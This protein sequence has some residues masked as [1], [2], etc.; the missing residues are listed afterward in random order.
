MLIAAPTM[1]GEFVSSSVSHPSTTFSPMFP[2][3]FRNI[4][5]PRQRTLPRRRSETWKMAASAARGG[6]RG[7]T[8]VER[9]GAEALGPRRER[10][11][12]AGP[13]QPVDVDADRRIRAQP[14]QL[15][16]QQRVLALLHERR[17]EP[18]RATDRDVPLGGELRNPLEL[19]VA[20]E[21]GCR[22]LR[23]PA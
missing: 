15:A 14:G 1:N 11:A 18:E 6:E 2:M 20:R 5:A 3:E 10:G 17:R 8:L 21:D 16:K 9:R 23:A 13:P 19:L 4:D 12:R 22:G 7:R